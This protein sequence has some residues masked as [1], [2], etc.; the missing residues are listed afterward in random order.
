[1]RP[2]GEP[3]E[4][5]APERL[6][7]PPATRESLR[8]QQRRHGPHLSIGVVVGRPILHQAPAHEVGLLSRRPLSPRPAE[9]AELREGQ[10]R[11][12]LEQPLLA[13]DR[14]SQGTWKFPATWAALTGSRGLRVHRAQEK[15]LTARG[16]VRGS[17]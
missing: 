1:M 2:R 10:R 8:S 13:H 4:H 6:T 5:V 14:D 15:P 12:V 11:I 3:V 7:Q 17:A 16:V 9:V